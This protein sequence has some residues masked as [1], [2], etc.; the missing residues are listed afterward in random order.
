M[1]ETLFL[2]TGN[3][4]SEEETQFPPPRGLQEMEEIVFVSA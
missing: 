1:E 3:F 2:T 4:Q